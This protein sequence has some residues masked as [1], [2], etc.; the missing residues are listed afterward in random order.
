MSLLEGLRLN[1]Y[2]SYKRS[3]L[4]GFVFKSGT[5]SIS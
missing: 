3:E 5:R 2:R 4:Y 1:E